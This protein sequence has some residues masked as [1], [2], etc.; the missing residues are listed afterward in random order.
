MDA[1]VLCGLACNRKG[2]APPRGERAATDGFEDPEISTPGI[3][4]Q[5]SGVILGIDPVEFTFEK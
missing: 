4:L 1:Q 5:V 2:A 3:V